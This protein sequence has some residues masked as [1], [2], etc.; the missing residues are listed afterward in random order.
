MSHPASCTD[1][2]CVLSYRDHLLSITVHSSALPTRKP[3]TRQI[4]TREKRWQDDI[5]A[6]R[7]LSKEGHHV[8]NVD[9]AAFRE[10]EAK[11][12]WDVEDRPV[13][14]DF[15]QHKGDKWQPTPKGDVV[16]PLA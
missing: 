13:A 7:R 4:D 3:E 1:P 2:N 9:G 15:Q 16:I 11:T 8:S 14:V 5:D 12:T 6:F 10:K